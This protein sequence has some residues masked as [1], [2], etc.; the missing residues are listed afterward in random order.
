MLG[1]YI[2][3]RGTRGTEMSANAA[4]ITKETYVQQG[5]WVAR[6][7]PRT[8]SETFSNNNKM[9]YWNKKILKILFFSIF[10]KF[11]KKSNNIPSISKTIQHTAMTWWT[12]LKSFEN[13]FL[14]YNAKTKRDGRTDRGTDGRTGGVAISPVPGLRRR[15]R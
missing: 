5:N 7:L 12:Y 8:G 9:K 4:L 14:S 11:I 10:K 2:K 15:G 1:P 3:S 13:A 6:D